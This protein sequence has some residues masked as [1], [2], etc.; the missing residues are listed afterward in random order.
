MLLTLANPMT[1]LSFAA[2]F[3]G[4]GFGTGTPTRSG[5]LLVAGVFLGSTCWW[6]LLSS[7][8]GLLGWRFSP[9]FLVWINRMSGFA[10]VGFAVY[11][12]IGLWL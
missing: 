10:I 8:A 12:L 11:I 5:I 3:A 9:R 4:F 2:F 7:G 6:L 1:I